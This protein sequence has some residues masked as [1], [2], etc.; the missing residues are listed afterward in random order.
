MID[1][2]A[3][4]LKGRKAAMEER[5]VAAL[6]PIVELAAHVDAYERECALNE[7]LQLSSG[8]DA[9]YDRSTSGLAYALWYQPRRVQDAIRALLPLIVREK[10]DI[11]LIDLGAG[12]G[13]AWWAC[14]AIEEARRSLGLPSLTYSVTA[15][16]A[17]Y[18]MICEGRGLWN[19]LSRLDPTFVSPVRVDY[20]PATVAFV[21]PRE[22]VL[23]G[24]I[25]Y[26]GY[27]LDSSDHHRARGVGETLGAMCRRSGAENL[28]VVSAANKIDVGGDVLLGVGA[29]G[30][31]VSSAVKSVEALW[32]G[33]ID[34]LGTL[35]R[36]FAQ[37]VE[38]PGNR[39]SRS[40][41][42]TYRGEPRVA[43]LTLSSE[44]SNPGLVDEVGVAGLVLDAVQER[45]AVP[46]NRRLTA[47]VGAAGSGKS[48]VVIERL[49]RTVE[50]ADR[51]KNQESILV[52]AFNLP[53]IDQLSMWFESAAF[54]RNMSVQRH[55]SIT[56]SGDHR[57]TTSV[58]GT[59][60]RFIGFDKI[61][62][63]LWGLKAKS[64]IKE[65][66]SAFAMALDCFNRKASRLLHE[67]PAITAEFLAA[68]FRRVIYGLDVDGEANYLK[69]SRQGRGRQLREGER[70]VTW[71]LFDI[72]RRECG[73]IHL[74]TRREI[75]DRIRNGHRPD[76]RLFDRVFVDEGQD[77]LPPDIRILD[78]M[79]KPR[80][81]IVLAGDET[82]ALHTGSSYHRQRLVPG[83]RW[84]EHRLEGSYR[85]PIRVCEAI[86]PVAAIVKT[87]RLAR[88]RA[89]EDDLSSDV[90]VPE[91]VRGAALGVRPIVIAG[92]LEKAS[93]SI[94]EIAKKYRPLLGAS[95]SW[96]V[97][98]ADGDADL[99]ALARSAADALGGQ[100]VAEKATMLRI[101]GLE[102]P[103]V[104]WSTSRSLA[105]DE[106]TAEWIYTILSRTTGLLVIWLTPDPAE[107]VR[108]VV[109][110][111][112]R[113]R[114]L[115]WTREA[116]SAFDQLK[117]PNEAEPF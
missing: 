30:E 87:E 96:S 75:L 49:V 17:S 7:L 16:E 61:P 10:S 64:E 38:D 54:A 25:A 13:A 77:F 88:R 48:R 97:T 45:A 56:S 103:F 91:A 34:R 98:A 27:L 33:S 57:F 46:T 94:A 85:L 60:V 92:T 6:T 51:R 28:V 83:G 65:D 32:T 58:S 108:K 81:P 104:V 78:T 22:E 37:G 102:R 105:G 89:D 23:H 55:G 101:K 11:H 106:T 18:P 93:A 42:W 99:E 86:L 107:A 115:F 20:R 66:L 109:A 31:W 24:A 2:I 26:A 36:S 82:Q 116:E 15:I 19:N 29:S 113:D 117:V 3:A 12:T 53:L 112:R 35:R 114:L 41:Q 40:P 68:E 62:Y 47:I 69:V 80:A 59:Q 70:S 5:L 1:E 50:E 111:L 110:A 100:A 4:E 21:P 72:R 71:Q 76:G 43:Y 9:M 14:A 84:E 67:Y 74:D 39:W 95:P 8:G 90:V 73:W 52:T 44:V 79:S 63:R